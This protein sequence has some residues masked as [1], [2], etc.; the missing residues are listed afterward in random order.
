MFINLELKQQVL[1]VIYRMLLKTFG[2]RTMWRRLLVELT[3]VED[4]SILDSRVAAFLLTLCNMTSSSQK[5]RCILFELVDETGP[6]IES[7][8]QRYARSDP[9]KPALNYMR[10]DQARTS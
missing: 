1:K 3:D 6:M 8:N 7:L 10:S 4:I 9:S 2:I 5:F